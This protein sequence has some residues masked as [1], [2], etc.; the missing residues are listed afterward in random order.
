[1]TVRGGKRYAIIADVCAFANTNGGTLYI[2]LSADPK[3]PIAGI[4]D[5]DQ[6]IAQLEKEISNRLSPPI[7][8]TLDVQE[9]GGKKL[10]RVLVPRGVDPPY[11]VD[12]SKI[13]VRSEAE[14]GLAVRDEIVG[15]VLQ[16]PGRVPKPIDALEE[17]LPSIQEP[18]LA[19]PLLEVSSVVEESNPAP[20][21]GVEVVSVEERDGGRYYTMRDLRNG[22]VVKN[23][24]RK[25]ARR[26][27]HYAITSFAELPADP[28]KA[29]IEW[30]G[31][32]G[33]LKR[34]K[35]GKSTRYDLIQKADGGYRYYFGVTD[36]G[37]HGPWKRLVGHEED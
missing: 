21:T 19:K 20:R 17:T 28:S 35:Q 18:E 22:N 3:K 15:L 2:G 24:T 5:P 37:I 33:L 6:A 11:A 1:M 36:D 23:V 30:D 31:S 27:W 25:S 8:C 9:T 34:R 14:T 7:Q 4:S 12:D 26:L 29:K 32:L 16:G 13:Y 10:V